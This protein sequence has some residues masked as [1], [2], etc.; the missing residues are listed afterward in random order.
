[1]NL[2]TALVRIHD[3]LENDRVE[4][5]V[6]ACLRLARATKDHFNAA[7]FLRELYP[8]KSEIARAL[9]EDTQHLN[10]E[11]QKLLYEKSLERWLDVHTID[12]VDPDEGKNEGD[13]RNV[14]MVA[15]G[16]I[17]AEMVRWQAAIGDFIFPPGMGE[18]D[19]AVFTDSLVR[20]KSDIRQRI[21]GLQ[22][23]K[24]RLKTRCLNFAIA[25]Q[26]QLD[27]QGEQQGF[28]NT[29][30]NEVNNFFKA[31][32]ETVH[33]ML[34]KASQLA[35]SRDLEDCALLL[36]EVRRAMK[37]AADYFYPP[38]A[39]T[40]ICFDG[41]EREMGDQQYLNRLQEFIATRLA[42]STSRDLLGAELEHL[43]VFFRRLNDLASKGVHASVTVA[44]SKQGLVGL[45]FFL[46]NLSQHLSLRD[47]ASAPSDVFG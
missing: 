29:V 9:H 43:A 33:Q 2:E 26:H 30:Q 15:A 36:T 8:N 10:G 16:E 23:V 19:T 27:I 12:G 17:E 1:M 46:F 21:A 47:T 6:M 42:D 40:V 14:L 25:I 18:L 45:Y 35:A 28:L 4:N 44:E 41:K 11:A 31:R 39:L 7:I 24:A 37:A 13:R 5:A 38:I 20:H 22:T 32:S 34:L 3:H